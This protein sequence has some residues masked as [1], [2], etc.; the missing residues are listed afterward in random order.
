M[1]EASGPRWDPR[2]EI[3]PMIAKEWGLNDS[4][5]ALLGALTV[6]SL[7]LEQAAGLVPL[8]KSTAANTMCQLRR[9]L[10]KAGI[11]G[12]DCNDTDALVRAYQAAERRAAGCC[13]Y[14]DATADKY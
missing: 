6:S 14:F 2:H 1:T 11:I 10:L 9:R 7:T 3:D 8:S 4:Q 13:Q 12:P 5:L